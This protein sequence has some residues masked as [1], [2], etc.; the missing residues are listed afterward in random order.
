MN[1]PPQN[2]GWRLRTII[3]ENSTLILSEDIIRSPPTQKKIGGIFCPRGHHKSG[4]LRPTQTSVSRLMIKY[5]YYKI[6]V[7]YIIFII[8][9]FK[10]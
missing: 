1:Q 9:N 3:C 4:F 7:L 10:L 8:V 6:K 2:G 5:L